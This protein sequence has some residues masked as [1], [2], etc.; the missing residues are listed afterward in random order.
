VRAVSV[1]VQLTEAQVR[2]TSI[3][4][5]GGPAITGGD[6]LRR[7]VVL[8]RELTG[9]PPGPLEAQ[10]RDAR[11]RQAGSGPGPAVPGQLEPMA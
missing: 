9:L 7:H 6:R 8:V 10:S 4:L 11:G 2:A 3:A 5:R 1:S